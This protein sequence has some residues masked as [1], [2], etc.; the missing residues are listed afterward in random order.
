[1]KI[2]IA[3]VALSLT[4]MPVDKAVLQRCFS[5][6]PLAFIDRQ[7]HQ[8]CRITPLG[9]F[10][11]R[12]RAQPALC[13]DCGS[14]AILGRLSSLFTALSCIEY[15]ARCPSNANSE[16][17]P[18]HRAR[19]YNIASSNSAWDEAIISLAPPPNIIYMA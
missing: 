12:V 17:H 1:L 18:T 8:Q 16:P 2:T 13:R 3:V 10:G 11:V 9:H 19:A 14:A 6:F 15:R 5:P 7:D 4:E